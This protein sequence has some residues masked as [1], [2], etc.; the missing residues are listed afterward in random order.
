MKTGDIIV[1]VVILVVLSGIYGIGHWIGCK[2]GYKKG[3]AE[4]TT[5]WEN[6]PKNYR[7]D[8]ALY[9]KIGTTTYRYKL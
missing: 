2:K 8:G 4:T 6:A 7:P 3:C 1:T 9:I 5:I